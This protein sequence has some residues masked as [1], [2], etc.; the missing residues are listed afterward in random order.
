VSSDTIPVVSVQN[1]SKTFSRSNDEDLHVLQD[2][3][4]D[5][6]QGEFVGVIGYSGCGK[7]TLLRII[8]GFEKHEEG[9][10]LIDGLQHDKPKRNVLMLFQEFNQL[11]PWKTVLQNVIHPLLAT[12]FIDDKAKA[13]SHAMKRIA[14]VR[15]AGFENSFPHELSGGMKQRAAV[16]RALALQP[17]VLLLDEPF[18]SVDSIT[19]RSLQVLTRRVCDKYGVSVI[20]VTHSIEE[21]L[22]MADRIVVLTGKPGRI[23]RVFENTG[24]ES[25]DETKRDELAREILSLLEKE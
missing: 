12:G 19:R 4:F 18:A 10:V 3:S 22:I 2:V 16:A 13:K 8:C 15:L 25:K 17:R 21:A 1:I 9:L 5:L 14:D 7:T 24:R 11:F 6:E 20:F 23:D